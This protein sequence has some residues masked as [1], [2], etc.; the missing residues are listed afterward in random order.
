[1]A[2]LTP[3]WIQVLAVAWVAPNHDFSDFAPLPLSSQLTC[4]SPDTPCSFAFVLALPST[5]SSPSSLPQFNCHLLRGPPPV[6]GHSIQSNSTNPTQRSPLILPSFSWETYHSLTGHD[7]VIAPVITCRLHYALRS[8]TAATWP[9]SAQQPASRTVL[10]T[11]QALRARYSVLSEGISRENLPLELASC[12]WSWP[13]YFSLQLLH[14]TKEDNKRP[15][16]QAVVRIK[17]KV[18]ITCWAQGLDTWSVLT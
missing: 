16:L 8:R 12:V 15:T 9:S 6:T 10:G 17:C 18:T 7:T 2:V 14:R 1:M 4:H 11:G 5:W 13:N 3:E